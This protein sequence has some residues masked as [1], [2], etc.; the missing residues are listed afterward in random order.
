MAKIPTKCP[1]CNS[2]NYLVVSK[3]KNNTGQFSVG[4]ALVGTALLGTAGAIIGGMS[5]KK[6]VVIKMRCKDCGYEEEY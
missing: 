6:K 5:G 2:K 3:K 1:A 4:K